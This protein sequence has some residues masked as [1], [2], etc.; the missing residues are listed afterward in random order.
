MTLAGKVLLSTTPPLLCHS[1]E[2]SDEESH[3]TIT[4]SWV[5]TEILRSLRS[6]RM[7]VT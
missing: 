1:E 2:R 5:I 6:L 4:I 3:L 7:T